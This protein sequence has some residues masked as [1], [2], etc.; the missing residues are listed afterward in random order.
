MTNTVLQDVAL[1]ASDTAR[2]KSYIQMMVK[3]G[4]L[5][6]MCIVYSDDLNKMEEETEKFI[7]TESKGYFDLNEPILWTLRQ[8]GVDYDF[9][10]NKDINSNE[11]KNAIAKASQRYLI[12][13][14]YGGYILR[15][16]LFHLGKKYIHVHAGI[17]PQYRGSTTAYY[18][19][20]QENYIGATA[21]F[22]N[23]GIDEGEIIV[24]ERFTRPPKEVNIDV[25]YEP[26][27]RSQVLK[28]ALIEYKEKGVLVSREQNKE[29]SQTYFIIHPVLKHIVL[30]ENP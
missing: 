7:K 12:Y 24:S 21:I 3:E 9:V 27:L 11:I 5:P 23:E 8:A 19:L 22:L 4:L 14:G 18:S 15:S 16:H 25:L 26:Y 29:E 2:T 6:S 1:L 20:L 13:S 28:K 17:L 10:E 30:M